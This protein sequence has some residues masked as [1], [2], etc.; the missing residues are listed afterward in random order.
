MLPIL[1][2]KH[3]FLSE[4]KPEINWMQVEHEEK[5]RAILDVLTERWEL[6]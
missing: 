4:T 5:P 1:G 3:I 6:S 2:T